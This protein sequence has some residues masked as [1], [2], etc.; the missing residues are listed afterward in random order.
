[1]RQ[2]VSN[3]VKRFSAGPPRPCW[4]QSRQAGK[5]LREKIKRKPNCRILREMAHS[6]TVARD[7]ER[8]KR[9]NYQVYQTARCGTVSVQTLTVR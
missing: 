1:V 8:A 7:G 3:A 4:A 5:A 6:L 9:T 2:S